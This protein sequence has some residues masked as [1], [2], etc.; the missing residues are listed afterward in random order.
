MRS[1]SSRATTFSVSSLVPSPIGPR[2]ISS[3]PL[4]G[5]R[6]RRTALTIAESSGVNTRP[7]RKTLRLSIPLEEKIGLSPGPMSR[8]SSSR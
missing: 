1:S 7:S 5:L 6:V 2:A 8:T 3:F 4:W